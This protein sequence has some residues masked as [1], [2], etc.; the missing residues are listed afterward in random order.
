MDE[1]RYRDAERTLWTSYGLAPREHR[2]G[3]AKLGCVVRLV[4]VGARDG[5]PVLFVH[6]TSNGASSWTALAAAL[7][8]HRCLL[9][10]RPGCGLSTPLPRRLA[11]LDAFRRLG[12]RLVPSVLD[13]LGLDTAAV[14]ATSFGG[15]LT[16]RAAAT[17]PDRI[18]RLVLMGWP[19]GASAPP[20]S[21]RIASV[22]AV[23]RAMA[24]APIRERTVRMMLPR[25]GLRAAL[26]SG[27]FSSEMLAWYVSL[28]RDTETLRN[29]LA[30][31][32]TFPVAHMDDR[33][34]LPA[35]DL[36]QVEAPVHLF[37]GEDD[38]FGDAA[39]ARDFTALLPDAELELVPGAGHAPWID[40][41]E[42][43][44]AFT[45]N[46]LSAG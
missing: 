23:G 42:R 13:V 39:V 2:L 28:L 15:Y 9:L 20:R 10:D 3:L 8:D 36:R 16:L 38:V 33:A 24:V 32:P 18:R 29:E 43:A 30:A 45:R 27:R 34:L 17:R 12:D 1:A 46:V 19:V 41:P 44:A 21:I 22:P 11:D 37:W 4:E 35:A 25:I 40:E 31:G 5:P 26:D 14:V 7:P 6:G